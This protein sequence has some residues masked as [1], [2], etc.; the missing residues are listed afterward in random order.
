[1]WNGEEIDEAARRRVVALYQLTFA[2]PSDADEKVAG[3]PVYLIAAMAADKVLRLKPQ[4]LVD[5]PAGAAYWR[6]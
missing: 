3:E 4:N 6:R 5:R 1:M 2:D